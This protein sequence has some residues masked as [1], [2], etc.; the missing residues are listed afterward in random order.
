MLLIRALALLGAA[1]AA[2]LMLDPRLGLPSGW[3]KLAHVAG[4]YGFTLVALVCMPWH[5]K[6]EVIRAVAVVA[7]LSEFTQTLTGRSMEALDLTADLVGLGL[8]A[9]PIYAAA[10]RQYAQHARHK[11]TAPRRRRSDRRTRD[12][13]HS[14]AQPNRHPGLDTEPGAVST[15]VR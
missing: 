2:Y 10:F 3:D 13:R 12:P 4:F 6:G 8:A 7:I 5:R 14:A 11:A 1:V 9:V 15:L